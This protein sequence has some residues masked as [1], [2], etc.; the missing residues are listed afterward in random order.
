MKS[1]TSQLPVLDMPQVH[2]ELLAIEASHRAAYLT[3]CPNIRPI[4]HRLCPQ[5]LLLAI[6]AAGAADCLEL[7]ELLPPQQ[8]QSFVDLESWNRDRIDP[9]A[10]AAWLSLLFAANPRGALS[11]VMGLDIELVTLFLKIHTRVHDLSQEEEPE[12]IP[13]TSLRTPDQRYLVVFVPPPHPQGRSQ[14]DATDALGTEVARKIV[15]GLI[16]REPATA[17]RYM[18][19]VR[20]E[21]PSEL[22]ESSYRWRQGRMADMG[23]VD[24]YEALG[25][26]SPIDLTRPPRAKAIHVEPNPDEPDTALALYVDEFSGALLL[27]RSLAL[28]DEDNRNNVRRQITSLCNR[29][30]ATGPTTFADVEYLSSTVAEATSTL[31]LGLE[32]LSKG[33]LQSAASFLKNTALTELF[34]VGH[35]LVWQLGQKAR[36]IRA[37]LTVATNHT[38]LPPGAKELFAGLLKK[39]PQLFAGLVDP[40]RTDYIAFETLS[41]LA[42]AAEHVAETAFLTA[43]LLDG[44]EM[45]PARSVELLQQPTNLIDNEDIHID[46]ILTTALVQSV[47]LHRE[48]SPQP[49]ATSDLSTVREGCLARRQQLASDMS[50][51]LQNHCQELLPLPGAPTWEMLQRRCDSYC[52]RLMTNLNDDI[53]EIKGH[54]DPRLVAT[55]ICLL[56]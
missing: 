15:E 28:V 42:K 54:I 8:V 20:W 33:E 34:R 9:R 51:L 26:Y 27:H 35:T 3:N 32:Y 23:Y 1:E 46:L 41:Q 48:F 6:H 14:P 22:E 4:L 49:L 18:E 29:I 13:E 52:Q 39:K 5:D 11:Q 12:P 45:N 40:V 56:S 21:M 50:S 25:I 2:Q 53:G 38:L 30:A 24:L 17:M 43:L 55:L 10:L 31:N 19:A 16:A 36:R 44:L 7:I 47:L 37:R